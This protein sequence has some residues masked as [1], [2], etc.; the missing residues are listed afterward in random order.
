MTWA[1]CTEEDGL[2]TLTGSEGGTV[3][4][5][6]EHGYGARIT[7]EQPGVRGPFAI[8]CGIY[9][10]MV[11]TRYFSSLDEAQRAYEAMKPGLE[12]ILEMI[13]MK[14]D[15]QIDLKMKLAGNE[16]SRFVDRFP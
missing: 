11:H 5:D 13:P 12:M 1:P 10:W 2:P 16:I 8:T 3:I 6:E 4:T 14:S 9:G 7:L 15:P